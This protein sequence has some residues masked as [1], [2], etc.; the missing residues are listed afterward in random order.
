MASLKENQ[1]SLAGGD[2]LGDSFSVVT[3][4]WGPAFLWTTFATERPVANRCF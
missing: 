2:H 4:E 3:V 1:T